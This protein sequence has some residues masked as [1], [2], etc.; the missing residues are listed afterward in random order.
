MT[1]HNKG[2]TLV[3]LR[4]V[5][6]ILGIWMG[7]L[8]PAITAAML[9]ANTSACSMRGRNLYVGIVAANT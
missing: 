6:G 2:S 9:S 3:E 4:V 7:A 1:K 5:I 8:F